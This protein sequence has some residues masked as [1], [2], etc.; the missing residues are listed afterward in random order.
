ME[1]EVSEKYTKWFYQRFFQHV[2]TSNNYTKKGFV[3][4]NEN[5]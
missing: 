2:N 3:R 5:K 1:I 4:K